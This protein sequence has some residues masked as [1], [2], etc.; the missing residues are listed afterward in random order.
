MGSS[1][2]EQPPQ[3]QQDPGQPPQGQQHSQQDPG[4]Q[5]YLRHLSFKGVGPEGQTKLAHS[6]IAIVGAGALGSLA[7]EML[8][9]SGIGHLSIADGDR[10]NL[11]NLQRGALFTTQD[12]QSASNK[13]QALA[14]HLLAINPAIQLSI[15][16]SF[17][18]AG[19]IDAFIAPAALVID[20]SD[21]HALRFLLNEA[22]CK[23]KKTWI[24][25]GVVRAEGSSMN[26]LWDGGPC[27]R[28]LFDVDAS[29]P[30]ADQ[31]ANPSQQG[32]VNMAPAVIAAHQCSEALKLLLSPQ[33]AS[34]Q[35]FY[36]DLW[37]NTALYMDQARNPDCP[38]CGP[39]YRGAV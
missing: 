27:F 8:C 34:R 5:R 37:H 2:Q 18:D 11:S 1:Q 32:L 6:H 9:R 17:L 22:C 33:D 36:T 14:Q 26:V 3:G 13:A 12:A 20:A 31:L 35:Y 23:Y 19:N 15:L 30:P 7:G 29:Q 38:V 21:N 16:P 28:C 39:L 10:V 24:Y 25:G 4:Q